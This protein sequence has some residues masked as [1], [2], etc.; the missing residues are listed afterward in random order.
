[1]VNNYQYSVSFINSLSPT[2][3]HVDEKQWMMVKRYCSFKDGA[4][5]S[6]LTFNR[7]TEE[8]FQLTYLLPE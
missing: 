1:M 2:A 4:L 6:F 8:L 7:L 5:K 3:N